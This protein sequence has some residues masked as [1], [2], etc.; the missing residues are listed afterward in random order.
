MIWILAFVFILGAAV[1][2]HEFG[3]FIVAKLLGIR[4][5]TFSVGF[6]K[7]LW[8]RRWGTTDYRL[9]LIPLGGYVKLG[10]DDSNAGLED[11]AGEDIPERERFDLR[12]RW[13]KFCVGVAGPVMNVV[14]ALAVPLALAMIIGVAVMPPPVVKTIAPDSA[15]ERAG[16]KTGDRI[17]SFNGEEDMAWEQIQGDALLSP[18]Q[19]LPLEVERGGQRIPLTITPKRDVD[20][21][22]TV[23]RLGILPDY[24]DVPVVV[25][26]VVSDTPADEAGIKPGDRIVSIGGERVTSGE[27]V[28]Q[29]IR[30]HLN[31][32]ISIRLENNGATRDVT[33]QTRKLADGTERLGFSPAEAAPVQRVGL[34]AAAGYAV[35]RNLEMLRL[36]GKALKQV[37]SGQRSVRDTF[38]GPIGIANASKRAAEEGG[39]EGV[40]IMLGFLS[41]NLGIFN[42]LP[43]PVLDGGMIFML[44][45]EGALGLAGKKLSMTARERIQQVGFVFLLL[46]MGFV[47]I[48]DV[49]KYAPGWFRSS[50]KPAAESQKK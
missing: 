17:V 42:L 40:F 23:G 1:I 29:Y 27:Q 13:Q 12:P 2:L 46:L 39:W 19:P 25:T 26:S 38:A 45:L 8:G 33:A 41:L 43:I 22:E 14:T 35:D 20:G 49:T 32:P 10:G 4:V 18:D 6:G 21:G 7:R 5:E 37:F 31:E 15:A 50:D 48:N 16:L 30:S 44:F 36:T 24:G 11:G 47:I 3:H 9:S 28:S 34:A